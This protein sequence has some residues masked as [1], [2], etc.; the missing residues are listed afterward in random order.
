MIALFP[1]SFDPVTLG[2]L[3]ILKRGAQ[4]FD[5]VIV[6]VLNN[7][8]KS[9]LFTVQERIDLLRE[10]AADIPGIQFE[11]YSG[12]LADFARK[13]EIHYILRGVRS[14]ADFAYEM[15]MAQANKQLTD[16]LETIIMVTNHAYAYMSAGLIREIAAAG[17]ASIF[18]SGFDDKVLDQWVTP[19]V[20]NML[21]NKFM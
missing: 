11:S 19:T 18:E 7:P 8:A 20:K 21:K 3:D 2:H 10:S 4:L 17:Y 12:L 13:R 1:G 9:P 6:A 15:P 14:E 16:E 5:Q